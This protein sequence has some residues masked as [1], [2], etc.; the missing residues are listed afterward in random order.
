MISISE[1]ILIQNI[2]IEKFG[3]ASWL[4][5]ATSALLI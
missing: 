3:G 2:L 5:F 4:K 1:I